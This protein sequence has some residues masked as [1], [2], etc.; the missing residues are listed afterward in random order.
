MSGPTR[1]ILRHQNPSI[2]KLR[3]HDPNFGN[4][5]R[6]LVESFAK[7]VNDTYTRAFTVA[8]ARFPRTRPPFSF[9]TLEISEPANKHV[10]FR[11]SGIAEIHINLPRQLFLLLP[12][13][14]VTHRLMLRRVGRHLGPVQRHMP[15]QPCFSDMLL[16]LTRYF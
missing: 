2:T 16:V 9:R 13:Q 3:T 10:K 14:P 1:E 6:R 12:H 15:Q 4:I 5:A 11:E 7:R 8:G